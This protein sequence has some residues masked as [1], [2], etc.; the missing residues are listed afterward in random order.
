[1]RLFY[2]AFFSFISSGV[3]AADHVP[4]FEPEAFK[5][6][7]EKADVN[8][9][10]KLTRSEAYREFPR[11]PE[12]FDEI[13]RNKDDQITM[14]EVESAMERRVNAALESS[15]RAGRNADFA[16]GS[17]A[18]DVPSGE[19]TY[20]YF[21]SRREAQQH[22]RTIF[23]EEVGSPRHPDNLPSEGLDATAAP[24]QF[25]KGF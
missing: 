20:P 10:R 21:S 3:C 25:K 5:K 15:V 1:M 7:F 16:H 8:K 6:R 11:M 12:F 2:L 19:T 24:S 14:K 22:Y 23:F 13:D 9:D 17:A 18:G 4:G